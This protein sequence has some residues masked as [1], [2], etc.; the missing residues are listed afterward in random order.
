MRQELPINRRWVNQNIFIPVL[1]MKIKE[2]TDY[3]NSDEYK[4]EQRKLKE[5]RDKK[6]VERARQMVS[7][8]EPTPYDR[9]KRPMFRVQEFEPEET[10]EERQIREFRERAKAKKERRKKYQER[11]ERTSPRR[12]RKAWFDIIKWD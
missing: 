8:Y 7:N 11:M 6:A 5:R 4:E 9:G 1:R 3:L 12:V 10:A 2:E